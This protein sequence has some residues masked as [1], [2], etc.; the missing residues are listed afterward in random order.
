[1]KKVSFDF[2]D[3]LGHSLYIQNYCKELIEASDIEVW[4]VTSRPENPK[5][6]FRKK[7]PDD[8]TFKRDNDVLWWSNEEDLFPVAKSLGIPKERIVFTNHEPKAWWF[9][10]NG[11][12]FL[13]HLDDNP[14][15]I[16]LINQLTKVT[17]ISCLTSNWR[18][19]CDKIL[20]K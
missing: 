4:I 17:P 10:K 11:N 6:F 3:C 7:Y 13:F 1:M 18:N 19:K 9:Q 14:Q 5:E 15:E 20:K 8:E 2:D 16:R 12:D